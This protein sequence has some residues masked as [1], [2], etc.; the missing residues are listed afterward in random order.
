M[1][2]TQPAATT[3]PAAPAGT[4]LYED[5][6]LVVV[7]RPAAGE[8]TLITFADLTFRP[9]GDSIW[10]QEVARKLKVNAIGFVAKRENWFPAASVAAAAAAVRGALRGP[11][12]TY[13][14][15]MGGYAAL[16]YAR[17]LGAAHAFG[18]CPQGSIDP[19]QVPWD[20]RFHQHHDAA[21]LPDMAVRPG[22]PGR[23]AV[24]LADPYMPEDARHAAA[25][26]KGAGVHWLR[27]P[28][29]DHAPVW[30]LVESAFLRQ[31]LDGILAEDL[32]RLTA[33][34]RARRHQSPHWFRHAGNA[35][36][37][38]GHLE[39]ANRL[40]KRALELGLSPGIAEQDIMRAMRLRMRALRD[41][42]DRDGATAV[43]LRQAALRP[44]DFHSQARAGHALLGMGEFNAAEAPFRAALALRKNVGHVYQGLSLVL[45]SQKRMTEA[46]ELC[47]R[48]VRDAPGDGKLH[49]HYGHLLLN[50]GKLDEA[51]AQFRIVL[52]QN[53]SHA[54]AL[55]GL[56]HTL[57]ARGDRAEAI[58]VARQ[59]VQDADKDPQAYLWL[60]QLLLFVGEPGEAEPV[61]REALLLAPEL[62][63]AHIGLAR[64][65]ERTGRLELAR[66]TA[67]EAAR[68]LPEDEKVQALYSRLGPPDLTEAEAAEL[69]PP[70]SPLRR[71]LRAFF[72][73]DED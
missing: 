21:L 15:S 50:N 17:L 11:A 10:G 14:Y 29:M 26:A 18:V 3:P 68:R 41:A 59:Q 8:P 9:K 57:A 31:M 38:R 25:L 58:A 33:L 54:K 23:F 42:G 56:S 63:A 30:L 2:E 60:G 13:G 27:T 40:W 73:R 55:L 34:M 28:F 65:L 66:R 52:R 72:S 70:A 20:K 4:I 22:E 62:G 36:F 1:A 71:F 5:E 12:V 47:K 6:H 24:L 45:G 49:V 7:H 39:M 67:A 37:R 43:A 44:E 32:P 69:A 61:F 53:P 19:R 51:E 16:K 46:L 35:A 48:G 64:A